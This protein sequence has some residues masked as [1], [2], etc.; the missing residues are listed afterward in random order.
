M[1]AVLLG[2]LW[3][4]DGPAAGE[5][6]GGDA[7][8]RLAVIA[9]SYWQLQLEESNELRLQTG[10]P[11]E[12]LPD[13]SV[14]DGARFAAASD[15]LRVRLL[16]V[17]QAE[18]SHEDWLTWAVLEW[19][20]RL[21]AEE[22]EHFW[23]TFQVTPYRWAFSGVRSTLADLPLAT[24]AD[25]DTY[26]ELAGELPRVVA[27]LR[28]NLEEQARRGIRV[29]RDELDAVV[30]LFRGHAAVG[31]ESPF[32]VDAERL[33]A[34]DEPSRTAFEARLRAL[35]AEQVAPAF[36]GLADL[37][38]G[39][40]RAEAPIAV[41]LG[42]YP[43]GSAAYGHAVRSFT[44]R[45]MTPEEIHELGTAEVE[46]LQERMAQL[47]AGF[48]FSGTARAFHER[49]RA[50]PRFH[51]A[52]PEEAGE[53]LLAPL[54]R[55]E[56][57]VPEFFS[58]MPRAPYGVARLDPRLEGGMTFG[59]YEEPAPGRPV[60]RYLYNGSR[61]DQR[62]LVGAAALIAHE[63]VPGHHFQIA[64]QRENQD[65]PALRQH[66]AAAAFTEGWAEYAS[67]L[68]AEMGLYGDPWDLYGRLAM[69]LFL[70]T[71]LV[72][73]T[74][75]NSLGWS[76]ERAIEFMLENLLESE[77]QIRTE[78]LRYAVDLPG[79]ALA[80]KIGA[81]TIWELR[82]LAEAELAGCFDLRRFHAAVLGPGALPLAVLEQHIGWWIGE[83]RAACTGS[84]RPSGARP[85]RL[86]G[87]GP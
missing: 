83:E 53:R 60:G 37:L 67:D 58:L 3:A 23:S 26:L 46:R 31:E 51:A 71:R 56:P 70:S 49:L 36:G 55:L 64:L 6:P 34:I 29:P 47:R 77:T 78:T 30:T 43:G 57:R 76:R 24:D 62:P 18:L 54:R 39:E 9:D 81:S 82:R 7:A 28:G 68:A 22:H 50:D 27:Q 79:Q 32:W 42:Q 1:L 4:S 14:E 72:V 16:E 59:Y 80:Y 41:G 38:D 87:R 86:T 69:D 48:G 25:L 73:D 12:D 84:S 35:L 10:L 20:T 17:P 8:A 13:F 63:L 66:F 5:G 21:V 65:L 44:T 61:L 85:S 19:E 33:A 45:E 75:M 40:H 74:G 52:T 11:I 2:V 15:A